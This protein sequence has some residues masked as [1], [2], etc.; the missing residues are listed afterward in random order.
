MNAD[1]FSYIL[2]SLDI[3][4]I[5]SYFEGKCFVNTHQRIVNVMKIIEEVK[6]LNFLKFFEW[7]TFYYQYYTQTCTLQKQK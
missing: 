2:H 3:K 1:Q 7:Y 5:K 4:L 6:I